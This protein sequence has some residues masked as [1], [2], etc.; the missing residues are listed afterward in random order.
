ML[1]TKSRSIP[2]AWLATALVAMPGLLASPVGAGETDDA[3]HTIVA[4]AQ[5]ESQ[6]VH[7][8]EA[9][10]AGEHAE[11]GGEHGESAGAFA[12]H[13]V[14]AEHRNGLGL[15]LGGTHVTAEDQ[16]F[17][18]LGFEYERLLADRWA[19]QVVVEHVDSYDAWVV[20]APIGFRLGSTLW[21][22]AGPGLESEARRTG[23][24][25]EPHD[26][27][28][29]AEP[30]DDEAPFFL[31]RFG[32]TYGIHLGE[33][34]RFSVFPSLNLDLVREHGEWEEAWVLGVGVSYHF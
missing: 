6:D 23:L 34:G 33:S 14:H 20:V 17:F 15:Y 28:H 1:M 3:A 25:P 2:H 7:D 27:G 19:V 10:H 18:T 4:Q 12:G 24:E 29:S 22:M 30:H 13:H 8:R 32:L 11:A 16:T 9:E 5:E 21:A 31:W 26:D